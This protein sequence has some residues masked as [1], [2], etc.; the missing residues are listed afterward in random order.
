M[1]KLSLRSGFLFALSTLA[2]RCGGAPP[3]APVYSA[4]VQVQVQTPAQ[5][6]AVVQAAP[7]PVVVQAQGPVVL[8]GAVVAPAP[9][10]LAQRVTVQWLG[11]QST[12]GC[13]F[14][15]GPGSLG[16]RTRLGQSA[17]WQ[18]T[19]GAAT[20][21]FGGDGG[22]AGTLAGDVV[23]LQRQG[24]YQYQG[25]WG[26]LE[27]LTGQFGPGGFVGEYD[28]RECEEGQCIAGHFGRCTIHAQVRVAF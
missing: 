22:F 21:N 25:T 17:V 19:G 13:F 15:S 18:A 23:Q 5:Q 6:V 16:Q 28:Y 2:L 4:Q 20:L 11:V 1:L 8:G 26:T 27:T 9:V 10:A 3:P 7:G 12:P 24:A 14:F